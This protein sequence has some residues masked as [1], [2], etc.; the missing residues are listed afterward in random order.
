M[1]IAAIDLGG[2]KLAGALFEP[3]GRIL[4]R[5]FQPLRG[6]AG[7]EV[8]ALVRQLLDKLAR[9]GPIEAL[10]MAVPGIFHSDRGTVWAPNIPGWDDYRLVDDLHT[11][12]AAPVTVESDRTCCIMG[13]VWQGEAQGARNAIFVAVGTGIGAGIL[14]DGRVLRGA[15]DVAGATGWLVLD[16]AYH[17]DYAACGNFEYH[18]AGPGIARAAGVATAEEAFAAFARG[19]S[20]ATQAVRT[21]VSYWGRAVANYVSLFNPE[22]IVFGGGLF[23]P[24]AELLDEIYAEA[25]KWAQ[26]VSINQ[27]RLRTSAL[28]ADAALYGAAAAALRA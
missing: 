25:R 14:A 10:G 23:G 11:V 20:R 9:T 6:R 19:D 26:P 17:E 18:A 3:G 13:E 21:A 15:H 24:A 5:E 27:V 8:G 28:G 22:V 1:P 2:T 4:Y 7:A 16:G 12:T